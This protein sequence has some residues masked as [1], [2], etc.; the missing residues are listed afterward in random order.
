MTGIAASKAS[1]GIG[2]GV[3]P[4]LNTIQALCCPPLPLLMS[5]SVP[6]SRPFAHVLR[7]FAPFSAIRRFL[8]RVASISRRIKCGLGLL[9]SILGPKQEDWVVLP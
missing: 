6:V 5:I 9:G 4:S 1:S 7:C 2:T 3:G 8:A